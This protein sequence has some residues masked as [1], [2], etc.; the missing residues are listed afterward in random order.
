MTQD[1]GPRTSDSIP[2]ELLRRVRQ[3]EIRSRRL[4]NHLFVGQYQAIFRGRGMEF[5]DVREYQPGDEVRT[6]DWNVTARTS[7]PHVKRYAEERELTVML[8]VDASASTVFGSV[9]QTKS[10]LAA[11]LGTH[12]IRVNGVNPDGVVRG[13]GIFASGWGAQRAAVYGVPEDRLG[14]FYAQR[15]LLKREVLPDHVAHAVAALCSDE[16][17][18][19]TGLLVPVDAG[20]PA[21]FLR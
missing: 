10:A 19:T 5:A 16:F 6:I 21:A 9:T 7:I 14:E 2:P 18:H 4:V 3:I 12:G 20:V 13:S 8:L 15:T 1:T 17:S 11:E